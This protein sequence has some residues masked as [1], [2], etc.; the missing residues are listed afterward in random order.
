MS[1]EGSINATHTYV[2]ALLTDFHV[3]ITVEDAHGAKGSASKTI[4]V[5]L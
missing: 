4:T 1:S 3:I 5:A 2:V